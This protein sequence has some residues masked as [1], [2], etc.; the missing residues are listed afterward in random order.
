MGRERKTAKKF[1]E[2][3]DRILAGQEIKADL[4][5]DAELR[6]TLDFTRK[7]TALRTAPSAQYQTRLKARLLQQLDEREAR[8]RE[9]RSSFWRMLRT[10]PVWAGATAALFVIIIVS[11]VW[12][13]G[14]FQ[15]SIQAPSTTYP[16]AT[17]A[18]PTTTAAPKPIAAAPISV[19]AKT[20]KPVY[21]FGE[22]VKIVL[23]MKNVT[24]G[25][26]TVTDFPPILSV[27]Q[28][29][30]K[31]PVYTFTAGKATRT[32]ASNEA[33][34]YTYTWNE[35]DFKGQPVTGRYYIELE[36]LDYQGQAVKL[37]LSQP[38]RFEILPG[39]TSFR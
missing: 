10:T 19:E 7:M 22:S 23:S 21:Q 16:A 31:Q 26:L 1:T 5:M 25:Q 15:P 17:T 14:F 30:T 11:I 35:V 12:R 38:V 2:N 32:L 20:D 29:D 13:S 39:P 27:M 24:D 3:L 4:K 8:K 34:N 6:A 36:D 37:N 33:A 28:E 9:R 18:A